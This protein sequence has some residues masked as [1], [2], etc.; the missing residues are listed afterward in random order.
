MSYKNL[1]QAVD[2]IR[3]KC[4]DSEYLVSNLD[5]LYH[6][7][8]KL[9]KLAKY[10]IN[11]IVIVRTKFHYGEI[12]IVNDIMYITE[13]QKYLYVVLLPYNEEK[14]IFVFSEDNID[15]C[16]EFV[17][18]GYTLTGGK[19]EYVNFWIKRNNINEFVIVQSQD[20]ATKFGNQDYS[21]RGVSLPEIQ[22]ITWG[23]KRV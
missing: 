1:K 15:Q 3:D 12:G 2:S 5:N 11:D 7:A 21:L 19:I 8:K 4:G 6:M 16:I 10:Q 18:Q 9:Y 23:V 22:G 14:H 13:S 17:L 20:K